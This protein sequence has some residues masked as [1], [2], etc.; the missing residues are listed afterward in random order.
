MTEIDEVLIER[1]PRPRRRGHGQGQEARQQQ[2]GSGA[3]GVAASEQ[4][5]VNAGA[6]E[7][8][9]LTG[10]C[11]GGGGA[12]AAAEARRSRPHRCPLDRPGRPASAASP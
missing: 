5:A 8:P 3:P 2:Q 12:A 10:S 4:G 7:A 1:Q 9:E 11:W 6:P